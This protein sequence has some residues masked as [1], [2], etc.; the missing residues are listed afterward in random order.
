[1]KLFFIGLMGSISLE[2]Y[3][4]NVPDKIWWQDGTLLGQVVI[5]LTAV[6]GFLAKFLQDRRAERV[7]EE[8]RQYDL[9]DRE[10]QRKKTRILA[11]RL[12]EQT[13]EAK[14]V[15]ASLMQTLKEEIRSD[16]AENTQVSKTA[17]AEAND[18]NRKIAMI[19]KR[20]EREPDPQVIAEATRAIKA[21]DET[22]RETGKKVDDIHG[23]VIHDSDSTRG[24]SSQDQK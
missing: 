18:V 24:A 5:F 19:V 10:K 11:R 17:F 12:Q 20:F 1:M 15:L 6:F 23:E 2:I 22:T 8:Q 7:R 14:Q 21:I 4:Q 9:E 16:I 3:A 13:E